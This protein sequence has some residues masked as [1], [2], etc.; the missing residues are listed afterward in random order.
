MKPRHIIG[1]IVAALAI[2]L[3]KIAMAP[4]EGPAPLPAGAPSIGYEDLNPAAAEAA[5]RAQA[6]RQK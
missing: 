6:E 1:W 3:V 2:G 4:Q 5:M